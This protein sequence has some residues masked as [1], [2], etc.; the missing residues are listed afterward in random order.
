MQKKRVITGWRQ[1]T[2][3]KTGL[4]PPKSKAVPAK[5]VAERVAD[6]RWET[7]GGH[8]ETPAK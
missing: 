3:R 1:V 7:E 8:L 5:P 4:S 2:Q 6:E